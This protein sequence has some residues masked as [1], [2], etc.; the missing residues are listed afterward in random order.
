MN[1]AAIDS[2]GVNPQAVNP[3]EIDPQSLDLRDIHLP[4]PISWWPIAPGWWIVLASFV[5][6]L[7]SIYVIRKIY[8]SRQ[9]KRD[10]STEIEHIKRQFE[11]TKNKSQ[12][13]KSLSVLLR[14]A[15]I[16]FYPAKYIAGLT[17]E[18]WLALLDQSN[19]KPL[20]DLK[21]QSDVGKVLIS[22]PYQSEDSLTDY[23][24]SALIRLCESWLL[25]SHSKPL[26]LKE[27]A[28]S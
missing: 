8:L 23:D 7:V 19:V 13:A 24:T 20:N 4:D 18:K 5:L 11:Q 15:S 2:Q 22:A 9:L 27:V 10:I 26:P 17:G 16:S 28:D 12:L 6:L 21:F 14:R 25:S 1:P 3:Q